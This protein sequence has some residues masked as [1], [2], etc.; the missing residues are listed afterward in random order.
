MIFYEL[1][2]LICKRELKADLDLIEDYP[3][4]RKDK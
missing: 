4:N 3:Q 2:W 1:V